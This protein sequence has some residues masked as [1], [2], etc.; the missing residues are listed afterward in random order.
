MRDKS[1][2]N[3]AEKPVHDLERLRLLADIAFHMNQIKTAEALAD[4]ICQQIKAII[5]KGI[6]GATLL[7]EATQLASIKGLR[8]IDDAKLINAGLKLTGTDPRKIEISINEISKEQMALYNSGRLELVPEG[9]YSIF[10]YR[11][12]EFVAHAIERLFNIRF[13]YAMGFLH[14]G[15]NIG[16]VAILTE[17]RDEVEANRA[18]IEII[19]SHAADVINRIRIEKLD[20][21]NNTRYKLMFESAPI[22]I[23]ISRGIKIEYGNPSCYRMFGFSILEDV[24]NLNPLDMFAPEYRSQI[25]KWSA[26]GKTAPDSL[27]SCT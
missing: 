2:K 19:V 18:M 7:D 15:R 24:K 20:A 10:A 17:S 8:G 6:V 25:M 13:V 23:N 16:G 4:F 26:C 22:A 9:F 21:D 1:A 3:K 12:P 27:Y 14:N 5:G 11:Y